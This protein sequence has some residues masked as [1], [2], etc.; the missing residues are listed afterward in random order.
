MWTGNAV[1]TP[2]VNKHKLLSTKRGEKICLWNSY[3]IIVP[4]LFWLNDK[5]PHIGNCHLYG[6]LARALILCDKVRGRDGGGAHL[7]LRLRGSG[8]GNRLQREWDRWSRKDTMLME[9][10]GTLNAVRFDLMWSPRIIYFVSNDVATLL[11]NLIFFPPFSLNVRYQ[12]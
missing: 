6:V 10:K 11:L 7:D 4:P 8:R 3:L 5:G 12:K 9:G 1:L 2:Y